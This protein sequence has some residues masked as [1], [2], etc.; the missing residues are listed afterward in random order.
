MSEY[1]RTESEE[2]AVVVQWLDLKGLL[3]SALTQS[4]Y[5]QSW[6]QKRI[7]K[8]TGLRR[9][10]P[11]MVVVVPNKTLLFI[12]LKR[13]VKSKTSVS[14]EQK[15]WID[16]LSSINGVEARVCYGASEAIEFVSK[17]I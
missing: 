3:F 9:G 5:T 15:I 17:Y 16:E 7:N 14:K 1:I 12:E 8:I 4:T 6:N 11:D 13:S 10:V 2:Q